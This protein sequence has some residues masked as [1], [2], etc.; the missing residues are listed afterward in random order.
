MVKELDRNMGGGL[1]QFLEDTRLGDDPRA[2]KFFNWLAQAVGEK[3]VVTG[4][5]GPEDIQAQIDRIN[6]AESSHPYW[7][8]NHRDHTKAV[9]LMERLC[10]L[11]YGARLP[12]VSR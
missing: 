11:K 3:R 8:A 10:R 1:I 12:K 2:V 7:D 5:A 4:V 9:A 6:N